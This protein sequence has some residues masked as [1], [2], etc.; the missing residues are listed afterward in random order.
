M[1]SGSLLVM[2]VVFRERDGV[3]IDHTIITWFF[4]TLGAT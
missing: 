4:I 2:V 3:F 1:V